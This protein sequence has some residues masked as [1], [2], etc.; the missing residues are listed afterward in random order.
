MLCLCHSQKEYE[1]CCQPYHLRSL[2][3]QNA[4]F[5]MRSRYSAYALNLADYIIETTDQKHVEA[6]KNLLIWKKEIQQFF[7]QT[8]FIDLQIID[9][10]EKP[11]EAFVTFK[12]VLKQQGQDASF[13]EKSTFKKINNRWTYLKGTIL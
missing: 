5:L 7:L 11:F 10:I 12:A 3:P 2:Y 9:F 6:L 13:T 4:L 8:Q 1:N